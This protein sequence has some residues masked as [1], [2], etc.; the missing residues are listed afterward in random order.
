MKWVSVALIP[1]LAVTQTVSSEKFALVLT[2]AGALYGFREVGKTL[3]D[4]KGG[5]QYQGDYDE[6]PRNYRSERSTF[7][8]SRNGNAPSAYDERVEF[9][10]DVP[11]P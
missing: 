5:S 2:F 11:F 4:I 8:N 10:P 1:Y 6:N 9:E 3:R 7:R